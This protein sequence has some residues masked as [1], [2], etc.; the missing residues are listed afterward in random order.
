[1]NDPTDPTE[2]HPPT[3]KRYTV[4]ELT[5]ATTA[6]RQH[7]AKEFYVFRRSFVHWILGGFI[8]AGLCMGLAFWRSYVQSQA[9]VENLTASLDNQTDDIRLLREALTRAQTQIDT[10]NAKDQSLVSC[11]AALNNLVSEA[12]TNNA[13]ATSRLVVILG[14]EGADRQAAID[15]LGMAAGVLQQ[16][17][18]TRSAFER[19]G[20]VLPCPVPAA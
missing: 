16:A 20:A 17:Q 9:S 10:A 4:N 19:N 18:A 13:L 3:I 12:S 2:E 11:R 5:T 7:S 8:A 14:T 6:T 1:M 15:N